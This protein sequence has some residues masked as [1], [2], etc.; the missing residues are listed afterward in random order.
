MRLLFIHQSFPG[1][2]RHILRALAAQGGHQLVGLG[3]AE[4][5]EPIPEGVA[6]LRYN[7]SRG[8]TPGV[9]EWLL[10]LD[11]KLI[12]GEACASAAA[13]LRDQGFQP[14]LI[15]AHPGWGEALFL[16]EIWPNVPLLSYQEFFYQARGV[17]YD[18][19]PELQGQPDWRDC[20]RL[21]FK[22]A[23]PLLMLQAS[24]W[25]VTPTQFQRSTF[26]QEWQSRIS[27]IHDGID[28][29][30]AAPDLAV[31]PLTLPDGTQLCPGEST[32]TFVNRRIEPY[33]GCHT[34][35]RAIPELQRRHPQARIVV[36]GATAGVS[37]GKPAPGD[38]WRDVFLQEIEGSYNPERVHFTGALAYGPFLQ[39]LKLSAC[40]VYLTYPFVL[41]WSL[42]EAMS[43][44]LPIVGSATAPVQEVICHGENGLLVDFFSSADLADAVSTLLVDRALATRLGERARALV[45]EQFSLQQCVPRQLA[46]IQLVASGAL[47]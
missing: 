6:Y 21:R 1:Q 38:R 16:R 15:C 8:N 7:L 32:I 18:F 42:L 47:S 12:R 26:P 45:L 10:D 35:I 17:D 29:Q 9:H 4:L 33:R 3:I 24:S 41:S 13:Q 37:Y 22:N 20:A 27:V 5:S 40:H 39:L 46:L 11:S 31:A 28:T 34:F 44:G 23:N 19:D 43:T 25:N 36:V 14:D 30:L 2:Y